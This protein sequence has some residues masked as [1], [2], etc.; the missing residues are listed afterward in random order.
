MFLT[1]KRGVLS[2][3]SEYGHF[4]GLGGLEQLGSLVQLL[5]LWLLCAVVLLLTQQTEN[6]AH[7]LVE[8]LIGVRREVLTMGALIVVP[9]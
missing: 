3:S 2:N 9:A 8:L 4:A 6:L 5:L 7:R 1:S